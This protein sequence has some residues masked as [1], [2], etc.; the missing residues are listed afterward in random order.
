MILATKQ[1]LVA[2]MARIDDEKVIGLAKCSLDL[3]VDHHIIM[4]EMRI[5]LETV[6]KLYCEGRYFL[7][8]L[9]IAAEAFKQVHEMIQA[10]TQIF[11]V[12]KPV[13]IVFG[14]VKRDIHDIGK[15]MAISVMETYDFNV[16]DMG[17]NVDP[18]KFIEM[19]RQTSA[20]IL[21]LTGLLTVSYDSMKATVS[22]LKENGLHESTTII[23]GGLVNDSVQSYVGSDYWVQDIQEACEICKVVLLKNTRKTANIS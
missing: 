1:M 11:D 9:L 23:I 4:N 13:D 21:C 12:K 5:G 16:V 6:H 17:V 8:D 14:T 7:A 19:I 10:Q 3:G 20:P 2:A 15:S 18:E 22:L